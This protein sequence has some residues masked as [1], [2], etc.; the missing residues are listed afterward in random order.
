MQKKRIEGTQITPRQRMSK[1]KKKKNLAF[2]D[3]VRRLQA[4]AL[5]GGYLLRVIKVAEGF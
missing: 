1:K 2:F 5:H 4:A 3:I